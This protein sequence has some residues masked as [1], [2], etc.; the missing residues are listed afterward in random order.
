MYTCRILPARN[1]GPVRSGQSSL[2]R[3]RRH[4]LR[5]GQAV[6]VTDI[7]KFIPHGGVL[8][9][10]PLCLVLLMRRRHCDLSPRHR[11]SVVYTR[12][13]PSPLRMVQSLRARRALAQFGPCRDAHGHHGVHSS[14]RS[15]RTAASSSCSSEASSSPCSLDTTS[16]TV[17]TRE[18]LAQSAQDG[19]VSAV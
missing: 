6:T 18:R 10:P 1:A 19:P 15:S 7:K 8:A 3:L 12:Y 11:R 2:Y 4:W 9:Q 5:L 14:T 13:W 16:S 17:G